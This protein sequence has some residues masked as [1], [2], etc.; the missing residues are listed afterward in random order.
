MKRWIHGLIVVAITVIL[1]TFFVR[2][3]NLGEVLRQI[4]QA[5]RTLLLLA[6]IAAS[7]AY[8][9]RA[10]R[11]QFL[12]RPLGPT[13]F[14]SAFRATAI[15]F[16]ATFLLPG[17]TGEVLRPYLLARREGLSVMATFATVIVERLL[18][19]I[20]VLLLFAGFLL[21]GIS[22][23]AF[24][25]PALFQ[26]VKFAGLA[27]AGLS[28]IGF[29]VILLIARFPTSVAR[30]VQR[31]VSFLPAAFVA[32][33]AATVETFAVGF[34]IMRKPLDAFVALAG[35][36]PL[37]LCNALAIWSV[38]AAF[39]LGV[40]WSGTFLLMML[41]VVG[42]AVP[43]PGGVGSFHYAFRLGVTTFFAAADDRAVAAAVVLHAISFLPITFVGL[44]AAAQ[45]GLSVGRLSGFAD[46]AQ[47]SLRG[48]PDLHPE[49][50]EISTGR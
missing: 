43:T 50:L 23:H 4:G 36:F 19:T 15:G 32:R 24:Q 47:G 28:V 10:K 40:P 31:T 39:H 49:K 5:D 41:L 21:F 30:G 48:T 14:A 27:V 1:L 3:A 17:R 16:A 45:E 9:L 35:A 7:S 33:I 20:G 2:G 46:V 6:I 12:L 18:D 11:W 44:L 29:A 13:R 25:N 22:D 8:V 37:W 38:S 26:T 34:T 42:V